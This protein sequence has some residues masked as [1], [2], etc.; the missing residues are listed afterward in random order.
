MKLIKMDLEMFN[1]QFVVAVHIAMNILMTIFVS[2]IVLVVG[3]KWIWMFPASG[4]LVVMVGLLHID[5]KE[6]P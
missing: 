4:G 5:G 6:S 3:Q 1:V 2:F